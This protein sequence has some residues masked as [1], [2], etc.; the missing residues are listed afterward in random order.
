[1]I[2]LRIEVNKTVY[3]VYADSYNGYN[4]ALADEENSRLIYVEINF[5]NYFSDI[6]YEKIIDKEHLPINFDAKKGKFY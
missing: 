2:I 5:C 1:M 4:Y 6:N 3:A